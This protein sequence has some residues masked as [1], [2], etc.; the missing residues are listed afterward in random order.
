M[1]QICEKGRNL[2]VQLIEEGYLF[3]NY[4]TFGCKKLYI[5]IIRM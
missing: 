2:V 4:I 3:I 5:S 1:L